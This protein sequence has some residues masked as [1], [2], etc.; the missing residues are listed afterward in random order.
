[1]TLPATTMRTFQVGGPPHVCCSHLDL[2]EHLQPPS[3]FGS[4]CDLD[5][6]D[7]RLRTARRAYAATYDDLLEMG[8]DNRWPYVRCPIRTATA[9]GPHG[10]YYRGCKRLDCLYCGPRTAR[11]IGGAIAQSR[12]QRALAL[13]SLPGT[14]H[15]SKGAIQEFLR[16]VRRLDY[17]VELAYALEENPGGTGYHLHAWERG[18]AIP[19]DLL[20]YVCNRSGIGRPWI[21]AMREPRSTPRA[22]AYILKGA[23][24]SERVPEAE[25]RASLDHHLDVNGGKLIRA[26]RGFWQDSAGRPCTRKAAERSY[27]EAYWS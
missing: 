19:L 9:K 4:G 24:P 16:L 21:G 18:D 2:Y 13:T 17:T 8:K 25:A 22:M 14:Y 20:A 26:T 5:H 27:W 1:M 3:S 23:I 7:D 15:E 6:P 10:Y 11:S 12:P